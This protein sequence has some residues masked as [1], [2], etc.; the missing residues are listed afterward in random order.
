MMN[1]LHYARVHDIKNI[2]LFSDIYVKYEE[3]IHKAI[4][5]NIKKFTESEQFQKNGFSRTELCNILIKTLADVI[6]K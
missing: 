3:Q 4:E 6:K 1:M 5:E 2:D